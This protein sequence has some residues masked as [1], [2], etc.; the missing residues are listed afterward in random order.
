MKSIIYGKRGLVIRAV[1]QLLLDLIMVYLSLRLSIFMRYEGLVSRRILI[2]IMRRMPMILTCYGCAGLAGGVYSMIW[3]YASGRELFRLSATYAAA[4]GITLVLNR[5]LGWHISRPVLGMTAVFSLVLAVSTRYLWRMLR[6]KKLSSA[7]RKA[8][9]LI[10]GAGEGGVYAAR[11][12]R[13]NRANL[14][15]PV[16]FVDD[17]PLK[18]HMRVSGLPICGS[19]AQI[20]DIVKKKAIDEIIVAVPGTHG[21]RLTEIISICKS[22]RCRTRILSYPNDVSKTDLDRNP[23]FR[24]LNTSDFL[25]RAEVDLD[26]DKIRSYITGKVVLVTGGGGSIGSEICR[27]VMRFDP[28]KLLV[29]DIYENCAYELLCE[30]QQK[31]GSTVPVEVIIGSIRDKARLDD[32]FSTYHPSVVFHAAAHKHVPLMEFSPGEAVKNNVFG[33]HNLLVSASEHGVDRFVQLSTDKAVNPTNVMGATKRITEML[34]QSFAKTTDMKCMAVRFGNVLGSHGS[35]I[36]LFESQIR[37]GGPVTV[38]HPDVTRYFMTIPEA[39]QLVLQAGS[40][41]DPGAIY[42]LDMGEPVRIVDLA[43]KLIRF[44]GYKPGTDIKIEYIGLRPGEKLYEELLMDKESARM[45]RTNHNKIF[46]AP[47]M[48]FSREKFD[49]Y[50]NRLWETI[51]SH[52]DQQVVDA[53]KEIV[54]TYRPNRDMMDEASDN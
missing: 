4:G 24:E 10:V 38:T 7:P 2:R 35:V 44:Y 36:P 22:T 9:I 41:A 6:E 13:Q 33:T 11:I 12:C 27:Q 23:A 18:H 47:P 21:E 39:A 28:E 40:L 15:T 49:I 8:R 16:A 29:F 25:S 46:V 26:T 5:A 19:S 50:L 30:L 14:G 53:L 54:H 48:D 32:V 20:P 45:T 31:Y 17:D 51:Q 43:E 3:R 52:D 37:K 34:L 42:V 1:G